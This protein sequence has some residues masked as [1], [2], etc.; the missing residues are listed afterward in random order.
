MLLTAIL[1]LAS[2]WDYPNELAKSTGSPLDPPG[3]TSGLALEVPRPKAPAVGETGDSIVI[4]GDNVGWDEQVG[5]Y[6][7]QLKLMPSMTGGNAGDCYCNR[8][9]GHSMLS[10]KEFPGLTNVSLEPE[11]KAKMLHR[12]IPILSLPYPTFGNASMAMVEGS[13]WRSLP[14]RMMTYGRDVLPKMVKMYTSNQLYVFPACWDCPP[15]GTNG[16]VFASIAPY[17]LVTQGRSWSDLP[18]LRAALEVSRR[19]PPGVKA[20]IVKRGLLNP[21]IQTL[22]R[23]SLKGVKDEEDYLTAAAH[24]SALPAGGLDTNRLFAAAAELTVEAIP[25]LAPIRFEALRTVGEKSAVGEQTY[26]T[27]FAVGVVLRSKEPHRQFRVVASGGSEYA[28]VQTH[29]DKSAVDIVPLLNRAVITVDRTKVTVR[30]RI[31]IAVM[32]KTPKS[33]WGAPSYIS[34]A[35]VDGEASYVDPWLVGGK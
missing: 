11:A 25:P 3:M 13:L 14:R 28:F 4:T 22:I 20:E 9:A 2:V 34:L 23:K 5:G 31:D 24:P 35:V 33:G 6:Y 32:A 10:L 17:W 27:P 15:L 12:G 8:D 19:L 26:A 30:D 1:V 16:D 29:G 7:A 21:T 18:Y